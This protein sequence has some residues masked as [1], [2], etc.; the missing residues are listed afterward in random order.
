MSQ[1]SWVSLQKTRTELR[2][3]GRGSAISS[4]L[5]ML[6]WLIASA[7]SKRGGSGS[8]GLGVVC[9]AGDGANARICTVAPQ[10]NGETQRPRLIAATGDPSGG[11]REDVA[12]ISRV[13]SGA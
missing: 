6:A 8:V 1:M 3:P 9:A 2:S 11:M 7:E 12:A 10:G 5:A 13:R 4:K